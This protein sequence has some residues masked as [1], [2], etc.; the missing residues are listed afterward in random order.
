MVGTLLHSR[1]YDCKAA[2]GPT[3]DI[4][5]LESAMAAQRLTHIDH[6]LAFHVAVLPTSIKVLDSADTMP[7]PE[8]RGIT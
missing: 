5:G 4:E 3:T 8:P 2:I 7:S 1:N 6:S